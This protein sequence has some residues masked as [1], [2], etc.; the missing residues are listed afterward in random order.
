MQKWKCGNCSAEIET[1]RFRFP[2]WCACGLVY[3]KDGTT[4]A[5][6]KE[7]TARVIGEDDIVRSKLQRSR[8]E[9]AS[10][11]ARKAEGA[12]AWREIH[13]HDG[14]PVHDPQADM[15]WLTEV[16]EPL[17]P[18][19]GCNCAESYADYK[20]KHPPDFTSP[21]SRFRWGVDL[22]NAINR[23]L[24]A[25]EWTI[26][27]AM[28]Y[29]RPHLFWGHQP[30]IEGVTA[31]TSLSPLEAHR[32]SQIECV[33]SWMRFGLRVVSG[34]LP[35]EIPGLANRFPDVEFRPVQASSLFD[36]PTPR[37]LD[38]MRLGGGS[39]ILLINSDVAIYS[40]QDWILD[41]IDTRT[42]IAGVRQNWTAHPGDAETETWGIDAFLLFP[43]QVDT[44]PNLDLAIGQPVWDY[45]VAYHL[46]E[47]WI[48]VRCLNERVF[49][50]RRHALN[51]STQMSDIGIREL[52][53]QY[54]E[55]DWNKWRRA[56]GQG[57]RELH[58]NPATCSIRPITMKQTQKSE[59]T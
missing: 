30:R 17:I 45:W 43:E 37:I 42:A 41:A 15:K 22:H 27:Q 49:F 28:A 14:Q 11:E 8:E 26:N 39:P 13:C 54:G 23:K 57:K 3:L 7:T 18:R 50:H 51:W 55:G 16:W 10:L 52:Q 2:H 25:K 44:F 6:S 32:E 29:W 5:W 33:R 19:F 38:L 20:L 36:R 46:Q 40:S 21:E 34:N 53:S 58:R 9:Y 1:P 48:D 47:K 31:V 24:E 12:K 35:G 4:Q 59:K 56:F